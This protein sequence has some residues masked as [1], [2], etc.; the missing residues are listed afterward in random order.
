MYKNGNVQDVS[1]TLSLMNIYP[2]DIEG[3]ISDEADEYDFSDGDD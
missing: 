3:N 1:E 2:D